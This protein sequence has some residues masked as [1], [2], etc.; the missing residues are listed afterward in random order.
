MYFHF[1][2][3]GYVIFNNM[4]GGWVGGLHFNN[5]F[6]LVLAQRAPGG[7]W[8][9]H[10]HSGLHTSSKICDWMHFKTELFGVF[11]GEIRSAYEVHQPQ[12]CWKS[13]LNLF[14][15]LSDPMFVKLSLLINCKHNSLFLTSPGEPPRSWSTGPMWRRPATRSWAWNPRSCRSPNVSWVSFP[16][17]TTAFC[18]PSEYQVHFWTEPAHKPIRKQG[19][20]HDSR[21]QYKCELAVH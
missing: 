19:I 8:F 5:Q 9:T 17:S 4:R 15:V 21:D 18:S 10:V 2:S 13:G 6:S 7:N 3:N 20:A 1:R 11:E 14:F 12:M 16:S